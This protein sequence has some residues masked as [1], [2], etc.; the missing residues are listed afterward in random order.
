MYAYLRDRGDEA[1]I[2]EITAGVAEQFPNPASS[3]VRGCLQ[4]ER[5]FVRVR[6]GVFRAVD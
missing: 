3:T 5:Y 1:T 2:A 4:N 6:R